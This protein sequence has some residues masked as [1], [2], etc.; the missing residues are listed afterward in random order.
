MHFGFVPLTKDGRLSARDLLGNKRSLSKLQDR[1]NEFVN[2]QGYNL[3]RG[4][5][6]TGR[7]HIKIQDFKRIT[8]YNS[9]QEALG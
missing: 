6:N 4:K 7:K 5:T 3:K 1:F 9:Q 8:D 2:E